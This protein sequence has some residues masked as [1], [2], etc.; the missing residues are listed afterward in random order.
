MDAGILGSKGVEPSDV[1]RASLDGYTLNI[2]ERASLSAQRKSRVHGV[3]MTLAERDLDTLYSEKGLGDYR[4]ETV[5]AQLD[6]GSSISAV[7][8]NLPQVPVGEPN[9]EYVEKLRRLARQLQLPSQ[10]VDRIGRGST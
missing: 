2:G 1:R 6:D 5:T 4:P 3:V 7:C 8:Y 10:Y 9:Q